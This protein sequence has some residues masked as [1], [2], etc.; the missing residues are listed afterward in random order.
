[1]LPVPPETTLS[2]GSEG[3]RAHILGDMSILCPTP[4]E[5]MLDA[6]GRP[7]FLWDTEMTLARFE[8]LLREGEEE[9]RA[10]LVGKLMRQAKP[11]DVF[12]FV[13]LDDIGELWPRI[14]RKLGRTRAFW[15]WWLRRWGVLRDE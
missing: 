5:L 7:Y 15:T 14:E 2:C 10:H 3:S 6:R 12:T 4:R 8:E 1:M 13:S 11:D 9:V